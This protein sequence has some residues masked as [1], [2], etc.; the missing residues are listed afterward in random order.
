MVLGAKDIYLEE[1]VKRRSEPKYAFV[2]GLCV[3]LIAAVTVL[4]YFISSLF[5]FVA[6]FLGL[7]SYYLFQT[8]DVEY[9]YTYVN[10]QLDIDK[11]Y[12]KARRKQ[13][14]SLQMEQL[15]MLGVQN[16]H[17]MDSLR[18]MKCT[19][20][21]ATANEPDHVVYEMYVHTEKGLVKVLFEPKEELL[22]A[23]RQLSPRKVLTA[24]R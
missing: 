1:L 18:N 5:L 12:G 15:E 3:F 11:I 20:Y 7:G 10:G 6:F 13:M 9:E 8:F 4:A 2:K 21:D 16:A 17:E 22:D 14:V 19:V 24:N 23:I